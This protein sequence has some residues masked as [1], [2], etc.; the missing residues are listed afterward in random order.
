MSIYSELLE[1]VERGAKFKIDLVQKTLKIDGKEIVLEGNLIDGTDVNS[2]NP[3]DTLETLYFNYKRSVPS[4]H[5]NGNKPYFKAC[6]VEDLNDD[7]IAF[8]EPRNQAQFALEAYV[9]LAGLSNWFDWKNDKHWFWQSKM[10][11]ELVCLRE[12]S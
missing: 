11:P 1:R 9:L 8:N 4:S 6:S 10:F 3:W 2:C 7:E 12:W 5:H